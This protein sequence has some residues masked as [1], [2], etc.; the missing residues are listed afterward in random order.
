MKKLGNVMRRFHDEEEGAALIE[1]SILVGIISAAAITAVAAVALWIT[2]R[3]TALCG[4]L[5]GAVC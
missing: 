1:Y 2:G 4:A 3:W 5:P